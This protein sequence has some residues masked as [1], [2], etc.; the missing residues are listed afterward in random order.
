MVYGLV[1][2]LKVGKKLEDEGGR[3]CRNFAGLSP[4]FDFEFCYSNGCKN[5][6]YMLY[7]V[8]K[9]YLSKIVSIDWVKFEFCKKK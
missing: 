8:C 2:G 3:C 7:Y 1:V 4:W 6:C 5:A 9:N